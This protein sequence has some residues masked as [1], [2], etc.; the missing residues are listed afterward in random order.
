[1]KIFSPVVFLIA[2]LCF[3]GR[4]G[5]EMNAVQLPEP[6]LEGDVSVEETIQRRRSVRSFRPDALDKEKISQL[7]WSAQGVTEVGRG[8]RAAPS[9]G[10]TYPL[11]LYLVS[12]D[13]VY[14]YAPDGHALEPVKPGDARSSL[15]RAA[16]GQ[17]F[18]AQA[19]VSIVV[20]A[21]YERT[22]GRYGT[23]RGERY[24]HI[25]AGHAAQNIHLQAVALGLGSVPV[26]AFDD[27]G[28]SEVLSLPE[29]H[30]PVYIIP[31]GYPG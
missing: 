12:E 19:P 2:C 24:V 20:A 7:L 14:N 27:A 9:A 16:L 8:L 6:S 4:S 10:A 5:A 17:G 3:A 11:E 23:E 22:A 18:V 25:E 30:A 29:H 26:G 31:V 13:G 28:V 1:M 15:A 21:V